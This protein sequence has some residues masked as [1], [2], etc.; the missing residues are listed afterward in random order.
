MISPLQVLPQWVKKQREA[1]GELVL[2]SVAE[3]DQIIIVLLE[4]SMFVGGV[5][6]FFL[7][8]TIPGSPEERGITAWNS[9][10]KSKART[11]GEASTY[12][13]PLVMPCLSRVGWARYIPFLPVFDAKLWSLKRRSTTV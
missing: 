7:D 12:D 11:E 2:T 8:N 10:H 5:L 9:Q 3:L 1:A 4:T 13:L 6:G